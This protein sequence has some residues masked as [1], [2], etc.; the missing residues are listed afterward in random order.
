MFSDIISEAPANTLTVHDFSSH[1]QVLV[2][3][4]FELSQRLN[5]N[6]PPA[7]GSKQDC[8]TPKHTGSPFLATSLDYTS[9]CNILKA[10]FDLNQ[11]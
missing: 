8:H 4:K 7:P 6:A 9:F 5:T 10:D 1:I 2:L 11:D 3:Q